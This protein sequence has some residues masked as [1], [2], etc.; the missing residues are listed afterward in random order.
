MVPI[1]EQ[2]CRDED[3]EVRCTVASG[4]HEIVKMSPCP[5]ALLAPFVELIRSG[6][7]DVVQHLTSR[8]DVI[9]PILYKCLKEGEG[10]VRELLYYCF[11]CI[12][13]YSNLF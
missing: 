1:L 12:V 3:D 6:A 5:A 8:L 7:V 9:L 11:H 4:F 2:F 13:Y 10:Q